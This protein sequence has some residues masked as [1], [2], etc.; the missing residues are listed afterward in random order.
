MSLS[1]DGS[2]VIGEKKKIFCDCLGISGGWTPMV[3]MHTQSGGKLNFRETDQVFIPKEFSD[4]RISVGSSNGHFELDE[5][6]KSTNQTVKKFLN[7]QDTD[8]D[9]ANISCSKELEKRNIWL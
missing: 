5:I 9:D 8:L 4:N 2:N 3:H 1:E 6:V 7:I